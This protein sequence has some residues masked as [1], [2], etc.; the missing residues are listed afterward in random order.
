MTDEASPEPQPEPLLRP[1]DGLPP[2]VETPEALA[3]TVAALAAG[4][5]PV[6]VDAER[7]SGYR[8]GQR[9]Y[10][11]QLRR[12]GAGTH[13][14][15]PSLLS[16]LSSVGDA[17]RGVEW[18]LHAA[19]QD[20]PC[21]AEVG[22]APD[23]LFDTELGARLAGFPRVGLGPLVEETLGLALEKGHSAADWS[24]R[25]LPE[26]WLLYAALDVEVLVE[27][28]DMVE[29]ALERQGKLAWAHQEFETV[30]TA[31]APGP[32]PD[33]WRRTSGLHKVRGRRGLAVV[34]EMWE[35]RDG[36]AQARD[37]APGRL[38]PDSAIVAAAIARPASRS[39]LLG[40]Q[41][42][43][44]RGAKRHADDWYASVERALALP[45][46]DLPLPASGSTGP[47]PP[48]AWP[49]RDPR[50]AARLGAARAAL[51]ELAERLDMPV[52]NLLTP[53]YVRRLC[54]SPPEPAGEAAVGA[55]LRE[56]GAR[57]WQ[58]ELTLPLLSEA[59]LVQPGSAALPAVVT[60]E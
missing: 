49:E 30:R 45:E 14:I 15:D 6:A 23:T 22:M 9:A 1:R 13:L 56:L 34:K 59:L 28:R 27:L 50:A 10:L 26:A 48:R 39:A 42:F 55:A 47:P 18:V 52:E 35:A 25:P 7:A 17:L 2:L 57:E 44:G 51:A 31:P 53:D 54:W 19:S 29:A 41:G 5:G 24:Q 12:A 38:L 11:V 8:Y 46:D 36:V 4:T 33:G 21:L 60:G 58:I 16:D 40:V 3:K 43:T 20:L 32:R 37:V